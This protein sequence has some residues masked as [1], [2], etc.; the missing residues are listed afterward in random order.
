MATTIT[1]GNATNGAAVSSDNTGILELKTGTG[2]GTT[3]VTADAS[4]NVGIGISSPL[5]RFNAVNTAITGGAPA[6]S[7]SAADP[8]AVARFQAG[9]VA[10]DVGA[11]AAGQMWL[12]PRAFTNYAINYDLVLQPNGGNVGIGGT[13]A[14]NRLYVQRSAGADFLGEVYL[15]DGTQWIIQN[16]NNSA[17]SY[18]P[19][20]QTN[21]ACLVYSSGTQNNGAFAI[22][23]W[24]TSQRGIRIDGTG[25]FQ[26]NSGYGSV[27]TAYGCRA[28]VNFD[29]T[30]SGTFAG[31]TSTVTRIAGT[32]TATV[33][34]QTAHG[35]IT[36]NQVYA[37]TGV[38]AG[39]YTIT[40]ISDT[41]FSFTTVA[42]TAL[43]N[44]S[45]TFAV[46]SIRASGNV[47][48]VADTAVGTYSINFSTAMPDANYAGVYNN[49]ADARYV[50]FV[51][52]TA[53]TLQ[54]SVANSAPTR[55]D[56]ANIHI[57][58]FR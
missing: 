28:W 22:A 56:A 6:S 39:A 20:F 18:S 54:V 50:S 37:L 11:Y 38:A 57:A 53:S 24:S 27:A 25:N 47:S 31:G 43:T 46:N 32:T 35:L 14:G 41:S 44:A 33:T 34:T 16:S 21:D 42:T 19:L 12:Q 8:N 45:I 26:F 7:G 1:A 3:A 30:A 29:G 5:Q 36:G 10:L 9:S 48:S 40:Y 58:I 23:Q 13:S 55:F 4:Q 15:T 17:G 52:Q 51:S 2:A 49:A